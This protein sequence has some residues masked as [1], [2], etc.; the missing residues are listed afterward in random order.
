MITC[1]HCKTEKPESE[2]SI[3]AGK[4]S[5]VCLE[6]KPKHPVG[7][8]ARR[9]K[10]N[11]GASKKSTAAARNGKRAAAELALSLPAGGFGVAA[12]V[13]EEGYLQLT[14]ANDGAEPDN[15]CLTRYE[16]KALFE[17]FGEW[18]VES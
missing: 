16:A 15:I 1:K 3:W 10:D 14:Q 18:I 4:P 7:G 12:N 6:C 13:T 8:G 17:K 11:G 9:T 2:M 5:K